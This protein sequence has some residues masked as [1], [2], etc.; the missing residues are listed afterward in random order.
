M[1]RILTTTTAF[2]V[3]L[4]TMQPFPVL[5][6]GGGCL[7]GINCD[8]AKPVPKK[9]RNSGNDSGNDDALRDAQRKADQK[10]RQDAQRASDKAAQKERAAARA[11]EEAAAADRAKDQAQAE[12]KA[13]RAQADAAAKA[14]A[15]ADAKAQEQQDARARVRAEKQ[16]EEEARAAKKARQDQ[17]DADDAAKAAADHA[18]KKANAADKTAD[19]AA[20]ADAAAQEDAAR[21]KKPVAD[22][23][24]VILPAPDE[25]PVSP[26]RK[27]LRPPKAAEAEGDEDQP[28]TRP[29]EA[30][31]DRPAPPVPGQP[32]AL[33]ETAATPETKSQAR[34]PADQ[35]QDERAP[36]L[37]GIMGG[38]RAD[39][40]QVGNQ[41]R[42][43]PTEQQQDTLDA[44][45]ERPDSGALPGA[46]T[47]RP[48]VAAAGDTE[49][50]GQPGRGKP[51]DSAPPPDAVVTT[52]KITDADTRRS[53]EDF[54]P[55]PGDRPG[56]RP[57]NRPGNRPGDRPDWQ[58][59]RPGHRPDRDRDHGLSD[60][61]KVGLVA[62]GAL[63]VGSMLS[64]GREVVQ[65]SGDRVVLRG[66]DG[67]YYVYKDDDAVLRRPGS[68][69]R[70]EQF[71]DGSTRTIV[72]R[73]DGTQVVTIRDASG[74]VLRRT[75]Y[76]PMGREIVL[77]DDLEAERPVI[78][79]DLPRPGRV[80]IS[81]SDQDAALRARLLAAETRDE[82]GRGFS[83]RQIRDI[84]QVRD[85]AATVDVDNVTFD[86]GS[87]AIQP[88]QAEKLAALGKFIKQLLAD[89][90]AE[91]F[92]VEG[93]TDA[94]GS[95]SSNLSLSD[96]RAES[97]AL[98]L[99]E[100]FNVP[101]E[102][103]VVQGYGE[104]DLRIDTD[105]AEPLNRRVVVRVITP[106][107]Q[108]AQA[109]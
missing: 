70:T 27:T 96:R 60:L 64:D 65:N 95:A 2:A 35:A 23:A 78:V 89:N 7:P 32:E 87:A 43:E 51:L 5:A 44:I 9:Q 46:G 49:A 42:R 83:L 19:D 82:L 76:D 33:P 56:D 54:R 10:A 67:R 39:D 80:T 6:E 68:T 77:F 29:A 50:G 109:N 34:K 17:A 13:A 97:V 102:N 84:P 107:L 48:P 58:D 28:R 8:D 66:D 52:E 108:T 1:K 21:A 90:P 100:Y 73:P 92:L 4:A 91:V 94:V 105:A 88:A 74:R 81:A 79:S 18:R 106:L 59:D 85:L 71:G 41:P 11:A 16:A 86:T 101:P 57:G 69:I 25:A 55:R 15:K 20:K 53:D 98:A 30:A 63:V 75:S 26:G 37:P 14:Q 22:A 3:A 104:S 24:P 61:E 45:L 36:R 38:T 31:E 72:E 47:A 103:L 62:L 99:T 40:R 93:H 12:R